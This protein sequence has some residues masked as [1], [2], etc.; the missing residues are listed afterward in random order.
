MREGT[1]FALIAWMTIAVGCATTEVDP[2]ADQE[3]ARELIRASTGQS[4]VHDPGASALSPEEIQAALADGLALDEALRLAL[5]NNRGL[6]AGFAGLGVSRADFVQAGLLRNPTLGLGLLL[7]SGGGRP[8]I[9][10]DLVQSLVDVWELP[11]REDIQWAALQQ[12]IFGLSRFA[13]ELVAD[14]KDAYYSSVAADD[15]LVSSQGSAEL[16]QAAF[17]AV[18][19][20]VQG[21]VATTTEENLAESQALSA[22]LTLTNARLERLGARRKLASL[23][24]LEAD[25]VDVPFLDGLPEPVLDAMDR[26]ALVERARSSRLDVRAAAA[27]MQSA[28]SQ[29]ALEHRRAMPSIDLGVSLERPEKGASTNL[30]GG[31]EASI[32]L[33]IFDQNR[34][35]IR[36]AEFRRDQLGKEYEALVADVGQQ[37][38]AAVDRA[39]ASA[40]TAQFVTQELLPQAE[41]AADLASTAY[42]LGD[43]TLLPMLEA[44][45]AA[46]QARQ[47][48]IGALLEAAR[49]R[50]EVE[51][52]AGAALE[53]LFAESSR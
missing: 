18:A 4:A 6:Q 10:A 44:R 25:L 30:L 11:A 47:S 13:G 24:S 20:R 53:V 3:R 43:T 31:P 21:G 16:A 50:V 38:R 46:L 51:R 33:P 45:H 32:E 49:T 37:V 29:L 36:R 35:Q 27:A 22:Q 9:T 17:E 28:E 34:A 19:R 12:Q 15:W 7:P 8:K 39:A 42:E 1:T 26:E 14:T 23:L 5:L 41:R 2:S 48:R 52:A 40:R